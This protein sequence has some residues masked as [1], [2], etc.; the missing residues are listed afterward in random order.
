[1]G[2]GNEIA[3]M[4]AKIE[5][6]KNSKENLKQLEEI[7]R[8]MQDKANSEKVTIRYKVNEEEA[9]KD[10]EGL[11]T[12][13]ENNNLADGLEMK[14]DLGN[15]KESQEEIETFKKSL[16][17][18]SKQF[19]K[20][21]KID[22]DWGGGTGEVGNL[23]LD[24]I[25]K[26]ITEKEKE[27]EKAGN[28]LND[29]K[30][31]SFSKVKTALEKYSKSGTVNAESKLKSLVKDYEKIGGKLVDFKKLGRDEYEDLNF[32]L[33]SSS[34]EA[35]LNDN[36]KISKQYEDQQKQVE[37]L[38]RSLNDLKEQREELLKT[39]TPTTPVSD[40]SEGTGYEDKTKEIQA[41]NEELEKQ[42]S[43]VEEINQLLEEQRN[44]YSELENK[45]KAL[46][47]ELTQKKDFVSQEEYNKLNSE[48]TDTKDKLSSVTSECDK[49]NGELSSSEQYISRIQGQIRELENGEVVPASQLE[50]ADKVIQIYYDD[51]RKLKAEIEDLKIK[52]EELLSNNNSL[53]IELDNKKQQNT[54]IE[55]ELN[56]LK[57]KV[58]QEELR[59]DIEDALKEPFDIT[60]NPKLNE[61]AEPLEIEAVVT[62]ATTKD[63][64]SIEAPKSE[65]DKKPTE[66]ETVNGNSVGESSQEQV[67]EQQEVA[68]ATA[69]S[70]EKQKRTLKQVREEIE[71]TE[72]A[73]EQLKEV[74]EG[75]TVEN[76]MYERYNRKYNEYSSL[77]EQQ[78]KAK[79][80]EKVSTSH[81]SATEE[82]YYKKW[83]SAIAL[84]QQL[85]KKAKGSFDVK[86]VLTE[87]NG[88]INKNEIDTYYNSLVKG[89]E[90]IAK[91][92]SKLRN[93]STQK[94]SL[95][96]ER[97]ELLATATAAE[98]A[99]DRFSL[100][101]KKIEETY[102]NTGKK[103][104][105]RSNVYKEFVDSWKEL[106]KTDNT[107]S[108]SSY[109]D[110]KELLGIL[111]KQTAEQFEKRQKG[112]SLFEKY[113]KQM[114]KEK[115]AL[116]KDIE[117]EDK[118]DKADTRTNDV[119]TEQKRKEVS[120]ELKEEPF[121]INLSF[122]KEKLRS[123]ISNTLNE[124]PFEVPITTVT[125]TLDDGKTENTLNTSS[126][127]GMTDTAKAF[128]KEEETVE[129][130][131]KAEKKV[132]SELKSEL[133]NLI[134]VINEK[135]AAFNQE[136]T[137]VLSDVDQE[138]S[139]LHLLGQEIADVKNELNELEQIINAITT[140]N[141]N[142]DNGTGK[143]KGGVGL[144]KLVKELNSL[145]QIKPTNDLKKLNGIAENLEKFAERINVI[146]LNDANFVSSLRNLLNSLSRIRTDSVMTKLDKVSDGLVSFAE[147]IKSVD[148]EDTTFL[149]SIQGLLDKTDEL[150]D[151]ASILKESKSKIEAAEIKTGNKQ[152][153]DKS[154]Q[155]QAEMNDAIALINEENKIKEH[156]DKIDF[157]D[158]IEEA[159][160]IIK[161]QI[162]S[163]KEIA[164]LQAKIIKANSEGHIE[165]AK[166]YQNVL[167]KQ[168]QIHSNLVE[169]GR[170]YEDII[171]NQER[172]SLLSE[173]MAESE[174]KI[175]EAIATAK[176]KEREANEKAQS[177]QEQ[178]EYKEATSNNIANKK[179]LEN[180]AKNSKRYFELNS[181]HPNKKAFETD[182]KKK[183]ND[184]KDTG[185][186]EETKALREELD[187]LTS[188]N[189]LWKE[190]ERLADN[191]KNAKQ[192]LSGT[193]Q[194]KDG[195]KKAVQT[196]KDS[197]GKIYA[198]DL[199]K[200]ATSAENTVEKFQLFKRGESYIKEVNERIEEL[201]SDLG[202]AQNLIEKI[203]KT[204]SIDAA[205]FTEVS[206]LLKS[207]G[208]GQ[209]YL[210]NAKNNVDYMVA[211]KNKAQDLLNKVAK[212][213]EKDK[214]M[215]YNLKGKYRDI[216]AE[217]NY[218]I[219]TDG[220]EKNL[221]DLQVEVRK[222]D[223][224][225]IKSGKTG[226]DIFTRLGKRIKNMTLNFAAQIF[227]VYEV[228]E[229]TDKIA[230]NVE[231]VNAE[232]VDL[233]KVSGYAMSTLEN[234]L[235][236][237]ADTAKDLGSS[238]TD[239]VSA[240]AD[241]SRLGYSLEDAEELAK[242]AVIYKNVGDGIDISEA[243]ESLIS[244]L[245]GF[246]LEA[247]SALSIIDKF[248]E[249]AM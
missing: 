77:N 91:A 157:K 128:K 36:D 106:R 20:G 156:N 206:N 243:N 172:R 28:K 100:A 42:K 44:S 117:E 5:V 211:D 174:K 39:G 233:A 214:N 166:N 15:I 88:D 118:E 158:R 127:E 173:T 197:Q 153:K 215:P 169:Q 144:E 50:N 164:D 176:R 148:F 65:T 11:K 161:A 190:A 64:V 63:G 13:F 82:D 79:L 86:D 139:K 247:D 167:E 40:N 47:D 207:I 24:E 165:E 244:T 131:V 222:L 130:A 21:I 56:N 142:I 182:V 120:D 67:V 92:E 48:L 10:L 240:T 29:L 78:L 132:I 99:E 236:R 111:N 163:V 12:Y 16:E 119:D 162:Q 198:D 70:G 136:K 220:S 231:N 116:K 145:K 74:I 177:K 221:K 101:L 122:D 4:S 175:S 19:S 25:D 227:S 149:S 193:N 205:Q 83:T 129:E 216:E 224:E 41:L 9:E 208:D 80:A 71:K 66:Q 170:D 121:E 109:T 159:G 241:W 6:D 126:N 34:K 38:T 140:I 141:I 181:K 33:K 154:K 143:I 123:E 27:L 183:E 55:A 43:K 112:S 110:N 95:N 213:R 186:T 14:I 26:Q 239:V 97:E 32:A 234:N 212:T 187:E 68:E 209:Q 230:T 105:T 184:E 188:I 18:I 133:T 69:D 138:I 59:A 45:Q 89:F 62:K 53:G 3:K 151:L 185:I 178:D 226:S 7:L 242:V 203:S 160:S 60:V 103:I 146:N 49:L 195:L 113:K 189:K 22:F 246:Q 30:N 46:Q 194:S 137:A 85:Q 93:L 196:F 191:Y 199:D 84:M 147:K 202:K 96:K 31:K 104:N 1:M 248:N 75:T 73:Y 90:E 228:I 237:Y 171:S 54:D 98:K 168:K 225:L 229:L 201:N 152:K 249:V 58:S 245:Q 102:I 107:A 180:A 108:A 76:A 2:M 23:G 125:P 204:G 87:A 218:L 72:K 81:E 235:G 223:R 8:Q 217:I 135:T 52:N 219:K 61:N 150:R 134:G 200:A 35:K 114:E 115:E 17:S 232:F 57:L 238:V 94:L 37:A 179:I 51:I 155:E 210:K 192:N 124:K